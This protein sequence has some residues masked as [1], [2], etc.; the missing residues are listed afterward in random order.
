MLHTIKSNI[1]WSNR[2]FDQF[3]RP[4]EVHSDVF[5]HFNYNIIVF[6]ENDVKIYISNKIQTFAKT[7]VHE[8]L[9]YHEPLLFS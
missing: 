6:L 4:L 7:S 1:L 5:S 2:G 3:N 8:L 9:L